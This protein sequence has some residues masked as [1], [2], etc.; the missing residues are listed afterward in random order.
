V[1]QPG[2][3]SRV[4][5]LLANVKPIKKEQGAKDL[6]P[7]IGRYGRFHVIFRV[8]NGIEIFIIE[9]IVRIHLNFG[10]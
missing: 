10:M 9:K 6:G 2:H 1:E 4:V 3:L 7:Y 8:F 5:Y